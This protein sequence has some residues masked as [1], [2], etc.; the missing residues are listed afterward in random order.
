MAKLSG[1]IKKA[2]MDSELFPLAT[3]SRQ[4]VPNVV[5]VKYVFVENDGVLW[6]VDNYLNKTLENIQHNPVAALYVYRPE[7]NLCVQIKG[8]LELQTAGPD[9]ERMKQRVHSTRPDLP[10]KS[11]VVMFITD[12]YQ[13]LPG[14]DAGAKLDL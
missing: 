13:C 3:A 12:L 11:L 7:V 4:G 6:L 5:P 9:Y 8:R 2:L 1:E 14:P 10:A